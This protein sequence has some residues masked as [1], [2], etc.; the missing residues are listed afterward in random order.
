MAIAG[1]P[2]ALEVWEKMP[3]VFQA[4]PV[5]KER[6]FALDRLASFISEDRD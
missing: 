6:R 3:H 4:V 2:V 1:V 5:L